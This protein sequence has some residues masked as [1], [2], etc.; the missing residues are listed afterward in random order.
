MKTLQGPGNLS[1]T[2]RSRFRAVQQHRGTRALGFRLRV[3]KGVQI[4]TWES[5]LIDLEKAASSK[6]YC[7]EYRGRLAEMG[8]EIIELGS[9]LQGQ[10]LA[11]HPAYAPGFE[12][13]HPKGLKGG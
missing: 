1:R 9:Y 2:V 7:D 13:F 8:L 10:A 12:A 4:P 3:H 11:F 5:S 6:T